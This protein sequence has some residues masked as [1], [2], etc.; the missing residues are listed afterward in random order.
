MPVFM[1]WW[2]VISYTENSGQNSIWGETSPWEF[3]TDKDYTVE[4][5]FLIAVILNQYVR[6]RLKSI[7][8]IRSSV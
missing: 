1:V 2:K 5:F 7:I 8:V 3:R 4:L 6:V